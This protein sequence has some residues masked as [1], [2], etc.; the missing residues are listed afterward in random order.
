MTY[1]IDLY[2]DKECPFCTNY[3]KFLEINKK[4]KL[5]IKNARENTKKLQ[6]FSNQGFDINNGFIILIN[7]TKIYQGADAVKFLDEISIKTNFIYRS[8]FFKYILYPLIKL[9]RKIVLFLLSKESK[10]K[11]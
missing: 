7:D 5:E 6:D 10:I 8:R 2:Y 4:H 11:F 9:F 3:A 1:K